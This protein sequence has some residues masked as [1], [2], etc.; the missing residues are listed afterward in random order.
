[1]YTLVQGLTINLISLLYT[2]CNHRSLLGIEGCNLIE[3]SWSLYVGCDGNTLRVGWCSVSPSQ[4]TL[5]TLVD[6][7]HNISW[8]IWFTWFWTTPTRPHP[9]CSYFAADLI[10]I[11]L[12]IVNNLKFFKLFTIASSKSTKAVSEYAPF[13]LVVLFIRNC[14]HPCILFRIWRK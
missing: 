8:K 6:I 10:H 2:I 14:T 4:C 12:S 11:E 9:I 1:M 3:F 5:G 7:T 13:C